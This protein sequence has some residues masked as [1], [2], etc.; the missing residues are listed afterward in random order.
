[1]KKIV[2]FILMFFTMLLSS[3]SCSCKGLTNKFI[4]KE[5]GV[6]ITV[7][8]EFLPY[9]LNP[10]TVPV[11]HF[12]Y[13]GV[14]ISNDSVNSKVVFV[15]NDQYVLSDAYSNFL[16]QFSD[17][18]LT[19]TVVQDKDSG[20]A[21]VGKDRL[22]LD[23]GTTSVSEIIIITLN[24]GTRISCSYRTFVSNG[25]RYYMYS[26]TENMMIMLEQPFMV[27][28]RDGVNKLVLLPLPYNTK[29]TVSGYNTKFDTLINEDTYVDTLTK[30]DCY[31]FRYPEYWTNQTTDNSALINMAKEWYKTH[32]NGIEVNDWMEIEYL[33][34][35]FKIE[36][37]HLKVNKETKLN[38]PAFKIYCIS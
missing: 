7:N 25:K 14:K 22:P 29:Y 27:L 1:M 20:Y 37:N 19:R 23:P 2:L 13:N 15:Q 12:D 38:E 4:V 11:I 9:M 31:T 34:I 10:Y 8:S 26:Y 35:K 28:R 3:C 33:G 17:K 21:K 5:N 24:D 18:F 6:D 32:C 36:F 30:T 16:N